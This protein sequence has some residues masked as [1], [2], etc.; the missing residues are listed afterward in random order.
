[1]NRTCFLRTL[2]LLIISTLSV[3]AADPAAPISRPNIIVILSDDVGYGDLSCYGATKVSTPHIDALAAGG[4]RF[5]DGHCVASTCTP[6]RYSIL[7][8]QYAFRNK[9]AVI[10]P[11]DA[12][13]VVDP[14]GATLPKMLQAAGYATGF[15]GKWHLGLGDGHIDWNKSISPGPDEIGFDY[16]YFLPATPD[17]VPCV[18]IED[19]SVVNLTASDP[20]AVN[21]QHKIGNEPTGSSRPD[22]LRYPAD[23][24]HSGTIVDH[25][26]RIGWMEGGHSAWW[27]DEEM[28][29]RFLAQAQAFVLKNKDHPFFLYYCPHNIH[30]PRA[31]NGRFLHTSECG[32][33]GDSIEELDATV[34]AFLDTL[35][36]A[37]LTNKTLVIF[38]SDNGPIFNDGYADG[39]IKEAN[40]HKPA[41]PYRGGK[42]QIFEGGTRVPFIV[43]W[44]GTVLPGTSTALVSQLDLFSSLADL[45][46]VAQ[47]KNARPDSTNVLAALLGRSQQGRTTFVEQDS[48]PTL[49]LRDGPWKYFVP[50][51]QK[52]KR[53]LEEGDTTQG[54]PPPPGPQ[55]YNLEDDPHE[56]HNVAA[57]HPDLVKKMSAELA[58]IRGSATLPAAP[59]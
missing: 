5:T 7:T 26:S 9:K 57:Q 52:G 11:G 30:V 37:G 14:S 48:G 34:G 56:D 49:A 6:S 24:Q 55:L 50:V 25:I 17:R 22:L 4:L 31:P 36:Q 3:W 23:L 15:V 19:R 46:G 33:R 28:A 10:L 44:P 53:K 58:R 40:G 39:S 54:P 8:G 38:S 18:Y 42:Y 35:K 45:A 1:M 51:P 29:G 12:P 43:S 16:S 21:Y 59:R 41:G 32:I 20:L 27:T 47:D 2:F 13:L